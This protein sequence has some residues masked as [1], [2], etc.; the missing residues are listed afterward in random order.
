MGQLAYFARS[1]VGIFVFSVS[2]ELLYFRLFS[3]KVDEAVEDFTKIKIKDVLEIRKYEVLEDEKSYKLLR[4]RFREYAKSLGFAENDEYLNRF[5]SD[6]G[7]LL[8]KK[9]MTGKT[10]RDK[11]LVQSINALD[12]ISKAVNLFE[13]RIYEW[14]TLHYPELK[15]TKDFVDKIISYGKRDNFPDFQASVGVELNEK[16]EEVL[17]EFAVM[18]QNL[19]EQKDRLEK[20]VRSI[21]R[22]ISPNLSSLVD[23]IL[24]ARL[25]ALAG[26]LEKLARMAASTIQLLGAE[27]ALFRHLRKKGKSPKYGIIYTSPL[28]QNASK[29]N[30]GKVARILSSKLMLAARIDYYSGRQEPKLKE[31]LKQEIGALK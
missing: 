26:S 16:D 18:I 31:E 7:S 2:G 17:V 30:K 15:N 1:P 27:K 19:N 11:L 12:D 23:E 24:A 8:S 22:E 6:F 10:G 28:I 21:T 20:Y 5:L 3:R 25:I 13:M 4:K 9:N 14:Y 29:D